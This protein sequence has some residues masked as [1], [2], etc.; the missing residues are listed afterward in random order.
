MLMVGPAPTTLVFYDTSFGGIN[1]IFV[2]VFYRILR[3]SK[4][5]KHP[6]HTHRE[7]KVELTLTNFP[8]PMDGMPSIDTIDQSINLSDH[9]YDR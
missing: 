9:R 8:P 7:T 3:R 5:D 6:P 4:R 1:T 2:G